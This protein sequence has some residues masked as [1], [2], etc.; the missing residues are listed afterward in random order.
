[1]LGKKWLTI[2]SLCPLG[3][4]LSNILLEFSCLA[5]IQRDDKMRIFL[6]LLIGILMFY[7]LLCIFCYYF[8]IC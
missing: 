5:Q 1:M 6:K 8:N 7:L 4:A 2:L 3:Y